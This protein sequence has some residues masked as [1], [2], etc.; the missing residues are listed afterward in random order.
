MASADLSLKP[1]DQTFY[2][3]VRRNQFLGDLLVLR[4][5]WRLRI[6][7]EHSAELSFEC[8]KI[9]EQSVLLEGKVDSPEATSYGL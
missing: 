1:R 9:E 2:K 5:E 4:D 3:F 6:E 8:H 7:H